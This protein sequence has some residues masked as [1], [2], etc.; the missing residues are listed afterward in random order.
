MPDLD[1]MED[2]FNGWKPELDQAFDQENRSRYSPLT[3]C[4]IDG[5]EENFQ[6]LKVYS[7]P[8]RE[9]ERKSLFV[10]T[11]VDKN[12]SCVLAKMLKGYL[13]DKRHYPV[14]DIKDGDVC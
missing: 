12:K 14:S 3:I 7:K 11:H 9:G 13:F 2:I 6:T 4:V 5:N 10:K 8:V 1:D